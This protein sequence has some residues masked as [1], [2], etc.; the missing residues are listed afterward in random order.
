MVCLPGTKFACK[1]GQNERALSIGGEGTRRTDGLAVHGENDSAR[2]FGPGVGG[3]IGHD[4]AQRENGGLRGTKAAAL[5]RL[6]D[7]LQTFLHMS[8]IRGFAHPRQHGKG[9]GLDGK[10]VAAGASDA[11]D[12]A[13]D[14]AGGVLVLGELVHELARS[15]LIA[16]GVKNVGAQRDDVAVLRGVR[17]SF[18]GGDFLVEAFLSGLDQSP[19]NVGV[20]GVRGRAAEAIE[21]LGVPAETA[22]PVASRKKPGAGAIEHVLVDVAYLSHV[23]ELHQPIR[24]ERFVSGIGAEP[25]IAFGAGFKAGQ[26]LIGDI[27]KVPGFLDDGRVNAGVR[28]EVL[29]SHDHRIAGGTRL[30]ETA[31]TAREATIEARRSCWQAEW[32]TP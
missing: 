9:R 23:G 27:E 28:E 19:H 8:R 15:G 31:I 2:R 7:P 18:D 6:D 1:F 26:S 4:R 3:V 24:G 30:L 21:G 16:G 10:S 22:V 12:G 17:G 13:F 14:D 32:D 5:V 20:R 11:G 29:L 25:F